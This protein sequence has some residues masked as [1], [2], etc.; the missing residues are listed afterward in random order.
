MRSSGSGLTTLAQD[1]DNRNPYMNNIT[2]FQFFHW[3]YP[4]DCSLWKFCAEQAPFLKKLGVSYVWLP[5]ATKSANG[6]YEPGYAVYDLFDLGEF[7]QKGSVPTKYGTKDEYINCV[8]ALHKEGIKVLADAVLNHKMGAD[9]KELVRARE[10]DPQDRTKISEQEE[11]LDAFTKF[12]FPARQGKYSQFVWDWRCF[13][14][15]SVGSN[16]GTKIYSIVNE[17]GHD[18]EELL[19][20]EFGN[21]DY[22]MGSDIEFR[23]E[24]VRAELKWW[25]KWFMETT[26][27]DGFRLDAV[28]HINHHFMKEWIDFVK[29]ESDKDL[30]ILAEYLTGSTDMLV[31]WNNEMGNQCQ[32][33]DMALHSNFYE[34]SLQQENYDLRKIFDNS[35]LQRMPERTVTF[36][37]SHDSQPFQAMESF[38]EYWF[39]PLANAIILLREQGIPCIF[40]P[41]LYGAQYE[42]ERDG[43]SALVDLA[44]VMGLREMMMVRHHLA[45]GQQRDY[46]DHG[47]VVGWTRAGVKE[48]KNSGCAVVLSNGDDGFKRMEMGPDHA[49][50][51]FVDILGKHSE[52]IT[53]DEHGWADFTV[54]SKS[55]SVWVRSEAVELIKI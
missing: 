2:L 30:F 24:H 33:F 11:A 52:T 6:R 54:K 40:Y 3:Y 51:S 8:N 19:D 29:Q 41:S 22:L 18:W 25:G 12:T 9:E 4:S 37:D 15:F 14:G 44:G 7:D 50:A 26:G 16:E 28:K 46:F 10:V 20:T 1:F 36:V 27:V 48:R 32:M 43:Q 53:T 31:K 42:E 45:Y 13:T 55:A 38:V 34:A 49:K 17:Y 21:F 47:S 39:K 35:L 5:P 23:N